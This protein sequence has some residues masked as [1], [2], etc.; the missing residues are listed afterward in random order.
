[1][2]K[3]SIL[4][5]LTC[6]LLYLP[7]SRVP[8]YF[9]SETAPGIIVKEAIMSGTKIVAV[10]SEFGKEYKIILDSAE[11]ASKIGEKLELIYELSN[12]QKAVVKKFW[13]YWLIPIELAWS[14]GGFT[15]LLAIAYATTYKPHPSAIAEQLKGDDAPKKKYE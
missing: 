8:D 9:D 2:I 10:Y 5:F 12:P 15:A 3:S 4:L 6:F 1:M 11:Y 14:F 7:F 13:G